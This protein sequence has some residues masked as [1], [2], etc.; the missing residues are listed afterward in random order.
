MVFFWNVLASYNINDLSKVDA[1]D[2]RNPMNLLVVVKPAHLQQIRP[3]HEIHLT[4]TGQIY[5]LM[6]GPMMTTLVDNAGIMTYY[7]VKHLT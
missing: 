3:L 2:V 1:P 6:I 5:S 7:E 4:E